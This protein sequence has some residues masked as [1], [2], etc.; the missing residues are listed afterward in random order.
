MSAKG[1]ARDWYPDVC[2]AM[3]RAIE[4]ANRVHLSDGERRVFNAVIMLTASWSKLSDHVYRAQIATLAGNVSEK[5]ASRALNKLDVLGIIVWQPVKGRR[6]KSLLGLP[7]ADKT[8]H[9]EPENGTRI[10]RKRDTLDVPVPRRHPEEIS[11]GE[12]TDWRGDAKDTSPPL[13]NPT[14]DEALIELVETLEGADARTLSTFRRRF[15]DLEAVHFAY[16]TEQVA[17][18]NGDIDSPPAYA[19]G[20]LENVQAG[21]SGFDIDEQ[22]EDA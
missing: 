20:L 4:R 16:A 8:G 14:D 3:R 12:G 5:T 13:L 18:R 15:R 7:A 11:R 22:E 9:T 21:Y 19:F 1:A 6:R 17:N 10:D 2:A